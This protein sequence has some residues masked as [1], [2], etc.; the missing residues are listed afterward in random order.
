VSVRRFNCVGALRCMVG[1]GAMVCCVTGVYAFDPFLTNRLIAKTPAAGLL[2]GGAE[3]CAFDDLKGPLTLHDAV[4]RAMC[5]NPKTRQAWANVKIQAA[6]VGTARAAYLPTVAATL[7][8]VREGKSGPAVDESPYGSKQTGNQRGAN[9]SLNWV[10][11]DFGG[12]SAA[13]GNATAL[14]AAAQASQRAMLHAVFATIA[15]DFYAAQAARGALVAAQ[16]MESAA[17]MSSDAAV[18]RV[19]KGV[20][21]VSDRLQAETALAEAVVTRTNA[22][23]DWKMAV[24]LLA[25]DMNLPHGVEFVL[26]DV[27]DGVAPNGEF[28]ESVG[29]L[30]EQARHRYPGVLAAEAQVAAARAKAVQIKAEG[31][32]RLSLVGQFNYNNRPSS[33]QADYPARRATHREWYLGL[34]MTFPIFDGFG[35]TYQARQADAQIELQLETLDEAR[36][37]VGFDVWNAYQTVLSA[38]K[39]LDNSATLLSLAER[40]YDAARHRY[41]L[42]A[43]SVLEL[44]SA[45][46]A[47]ASGKK[48]RIQALTDWRSARLQ[49]AAKLG[50]TEIRGQTIR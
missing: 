7:Q 36:R 31:L 39:N 50:D 35:R 24:G 4:E 40:S 11:Y 15:S 45:Q 8:Q 44:L 42:G 22:E 47:L 30:I 32:P 18:A 20:A 10:L 46:A 43:G 21:P 25:A 26:P 17:R 16:E 29:A 48:Q 14:W 49:L 27:E 6:A 13:L 33:L 41:R 12:R 5:N 34:Q 9:V 23:R 28:I 1:W 3:V 37:Q 38:T 19:A 2:G